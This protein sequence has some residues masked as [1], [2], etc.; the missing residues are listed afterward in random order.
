MTAEGYEYF[1]VAADV[2]VTAWGVD[3]AGCLRQCALAVFNLIVP[4]ASVEPR[5][6]RE[7]AARGAPVEALAVKD[8]SEV[9]K[10]SI[11]KVGN[12]DQK[13]NYPAARSTPTVEGNFLYALG[14]DGDLVCLD[15]ASGS[16][17]WGKSLR[18]DFGGHPGQW[19][20]SESPLVDGDVLVCTPGGKEAT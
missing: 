1:D 19:A 18:D 2:G 7:V 5:E 4:T 9:W 6:T 17:K 13:P 15:I 11:G 10:T 3:L 12:P 20:Y 8:G 16:K 14:S